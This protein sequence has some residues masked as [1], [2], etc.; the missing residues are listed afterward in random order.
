MDKLFGSAGKVK[1]MKLFIYNPDQFFDMKTIADRTR[2]SSEHARKETTLLSKIGLIKSKGGSGNKKY[3]LNEIFPY[4]KQLRELMTHTITASHDDIVK[5]IAKTCKLKS[6]VL[7]GLFIGRSESRAD[8]LIIGNQ[9]NKTAFTKCMKNIEAEMGRELSYA[10]L[11]TEDFKYR[12]SVGDRLV[13]DVL[14]YPHQIAYDR[15][16]LNK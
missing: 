3:F 11:E 5:K 10:I 2:L 4:I 14:D 15:I 7:S 9:F 6:V 1:V 16:G 8:M 13:R 12:L